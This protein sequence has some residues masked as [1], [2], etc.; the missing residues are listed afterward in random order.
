[1]KKQFRKLYLVA[2]IVFGIF[3][4]LRIRIPEDVTKFEFFEV[5]L[6]QNSRFSYSLIPDGSGII[7][8]DSSQIP[9]TYNDKLKNSFYYL[10]FEDKSV[11][12]IHE[13]ESGRA[14]AVFWVNPETAILASQAEWGSCYNDT[15]QEGTISFNLE[16][17]E[18]QPAEC[19]EGKGLINPQFDATQYS[20]DSKKKIYSINQ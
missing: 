15:L 10:N 9:S 11:Q 20:S 6:P 3:I 19:L 7:Y 13:I 12:L 14:L 5:V 18:K 17:K 8:I 4:G 1:M 16:T 2:I